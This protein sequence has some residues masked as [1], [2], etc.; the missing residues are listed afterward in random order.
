MGTGEVW[1]RPGV[2]L[3]SLKPENDNGHTKTA[4]TQKSKK[5]HLTGTLGNVL[6]QNKMV[7]ECF[8]PL[9]LDRDSNPGP[10]TVLLSRGGR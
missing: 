2:R 8:K 5:R 9:G 10:V 7:K 1:Q 4:K 3:T 6:S